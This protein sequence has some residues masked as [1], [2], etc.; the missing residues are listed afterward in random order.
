MWDFGSL[1]RPRGQL[2]GLALRRWA[3]ERGVATCAEADAV[4]RED[5]L[6]SLCEAHFVLDCMPGHASGC[7]AD[8][9][10]TPW[11]R[12]QL[13]RLLDA[14]SFEKRSQL[15]QGIATARPHCPGAAELAEAEPPEEEKPADQPEAA[16]GTGEGHAPRGVIRIEPPYLDGEIDP[17]EISR[18]I[19]TNLGKFQDCYDSALKRKDT[20]QGRIQ[21]HWTITPKGKM[22]G[23]EIQDDDVGDP[24]FLQCLR[25]AIAQMP[26]PVPADG[27]KASVGLVF[28]FRSP[29]SL[30]KEGSP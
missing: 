8:K 3:G 20:A 28:I 27:G 6:A 18:A 25:A 19:H 22:K 23:M 12:E 9:L 13:K 17:A 5:D 15:L 1:A 11:G 26:L 21:L 30:A 24:R 7:R 16:Q 4:D 2:D 29:N 10:R 14:S